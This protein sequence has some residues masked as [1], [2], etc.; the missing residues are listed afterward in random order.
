RICRFVPFMSSI[1]AEMEVDTVA[2]LPFRNPL[3]VAY[4]L[5]RRD[6]LPLSKSLL[7]WL[8]HVLEAEH[9]SRHM[10]RYLI[11]HEEFLIDWRNQID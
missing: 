3:E 11:R 6:G 7:L 1:L 9:H 5:K 8:R 2:L 10:P 4:S